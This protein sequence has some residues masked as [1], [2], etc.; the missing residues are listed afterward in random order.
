[1]HDDARPGPWRAAL[2]TI[3]ALLVLLLA[4]AQGTSELVQARML[5]LGEDTWPGYAELRKDPQPPDCDP[6]AIG[7]GSEA[8]KTEDD[9]LLDDLFGEEDGAPSEPEAAP[10]A[11]APSEGGDDDDLLD[12]LFGDEPEAGPSAAAI[13]AAKDKCRT[14]HADY[15]ALITRITP[16][17]RVYRQVDHFLSAITNIG[18]SSAR[19]SLVFLIAICAA[20]ASAVGAHIS[21]RPVRTTRDAQVSGALQLLVNTI[22]A[23]SCIA[24]WRIVSTSGVEGGEP[25][26]ALVWATGFLA[27]AGFALRDVWRPP[28]DLE[29]GGT[30]GGALL[31]V[32]LYVSM[33]LISA[34]WFLGIEWH[35][36]GIAI[37]LDKLTEHSALYLQVGMFVWAGMLLKQTRLAQ[38]VFDVL[39]PW[40][41]SPEMMAAVVVLAAA[42][43]TAYSGASGIFVIA[44]GATIY[45]ELRRAGA[46]NQLALASTAMSGSM[47]VV[48][49]PCLLVVIVAS[50]NR[51]VTTTMLFGAGYQVFLLT[52]VLFLIVLFLTRRAPLHIAPWSEAIAPT[53]QALMGLMPYALLMV[54]VLGVFGLGLNAWLDEHSA[55]RILLV[56]LLAFLLWEGGRRSKQGGEST[57]PRLRDATTETTLHIGAL[58]ALMGLSVAFGGVIERAHVMDMVPEHLGGPLPTMA[59]LTVMLVL[60]GMVMDPYGAV[61]LVSATLAHVADRNGVDALHF[62]MVVLVAF[63]LG[64][65]TPPVALNHLLTRAVVG[66]DADDP[67]VPEGAGFWYRHE[68]LLLPVTVM[69]TALVLVAFVPLLMA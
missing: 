24:H 62:W 20:T 2:S 6:D 4:V 13:E 50:L 57:Y 56:V 49:N 36:S 42:I 55:A 47:G 43:P 64:Y 46:R 51:Q 26:L 37:Y 27:M 12:G 61:I 17:V 63:E 68:R 28:A 1:M 8:P 60:I 9:A 14:A 54:A 34:V 25:W 53:Q 45:E 7:A 29:E 32:P 21:L 22:V 11:P 15:A 58:L 19:P 3:P 39:R 31:T 35:P 30:F 16:T 10:D 48:L 52:A 18:R 67:D 66:Q 59:L 23:L 5:A 41:M 38:A 44:A 33:A 69:A 65:L 40:S